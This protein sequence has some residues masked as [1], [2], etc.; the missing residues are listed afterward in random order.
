MIET[1]FRIHVVID[2]LSETAIA[3]TAT[4]IGDYNRERDWEREK[5]MERLRKEN[6]QLLEENSR[7][8]IASNAP[9]TTN[10]G[11]GNFAGYTPSEVDAKIKAAL[12]KQET[13]LNAAADL[14]MKEKVDELVAKRATWS[15]PILWFMFFVSFGLN[16]YLW[17][18]WRASFTRYQELA[19]DLRQTF[20]TTYQLDASNSCANIS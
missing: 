10:A 6:R 11:L 12:T 9:P 20:F 14:K 13:E 1:I 5:E 7:N 8:R 4:M 18:I 19:D 17:W 15:G 2:R 16:M 3:M